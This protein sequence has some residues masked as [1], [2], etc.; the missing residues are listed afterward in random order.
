MNV[1]FSCIPKCGK[2]NSWAAVDRAHL[3][4]PFDCTCSLCRNLYVHLFSKDQPLQHEECIVDHN[5]VASESVSM[6]LLKCV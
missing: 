4:H 2:G 5:H 3:Q 1:V 6:S